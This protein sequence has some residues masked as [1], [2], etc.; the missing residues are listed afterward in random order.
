MENLQETL[1]QKMPDQDELV[2]KV[3]LW[4]FKS[5]QIVFTN[6]CFDILHAGHIHLLTQAAALGDKLIV[7]LNTDASVKRL[8]GEGRPLQDERTRQTV[9]AALHCVDRVVLFD[10]DTPLNLIKLISPDV[11][12]KGGDYTI[13]NIVGADWV[14]QHGGEVRTIDLL[15]GYSTTAVTQ[16]MKGL[17]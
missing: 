11:L 10:E 6:G 7:G 17:G 4:R 12:V 8:K 9:M 3:N 5:E 16:K 1:L 15:D 2:K 13:K 14:L